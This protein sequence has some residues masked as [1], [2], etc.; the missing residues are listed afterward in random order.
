[1]QF[2]WKKRASVACMA[3]ALGTLPTVASAESFNGP[4]AGLEAGIGIVKVEGSTIA[5]PFKDTDTSAIAGVVAGY[6]MPLG[7][8]SPI[9]LGV[10]GNLGVY[11][12]GGDARYG[13]SGIGGVRIGDKALAYLRAGYGWLEGQPNG[14]TGKLDG[15][16]LGGGAEV[17][18]SDAISARADYKYLDL[19]GVNF[20]D[21]TLSFEGHEIAAS[22]IFNF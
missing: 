3:L 5:G 14:S 22:L 9:M 11:A 8:N 1:M 10:E 16:V 2:S 19:G 20:P 7:E 21:N 13:V 15:L 4:Y 12:D 6:R 17:Q 18:L